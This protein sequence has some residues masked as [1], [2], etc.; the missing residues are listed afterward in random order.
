MSYTV[1]VQNASGTILAVSKDES[2]ATVKVVN[3]TYSGAPV[4]NNEIVIS[5][6]QIGDTQIV[7]SDE[8]GNTATLNVKVE[9]VNLFWSMVCIYKKISLVE[10]EIVIDGTDETS[11]ANIRT[12]ILV[13]RAKEKRFVIKVGQCFPWNVYK[14]QVLDKDDTML[15]E[16]VGGT[17]SDSNYKFYLPVQDETSDVKTFSFYEETNSFG[18]W[19]VEDITDDYKTQY[20]NVKVL[21]KMQVEKQ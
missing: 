17:L 3:A 4:Q 9:D 6:V 12:D 2:I 8:D 20:P 18:Q 5:G 16:L 7:V 11:A 14:M 10:D 15:Y 13:N 21:L 1:N 19:L